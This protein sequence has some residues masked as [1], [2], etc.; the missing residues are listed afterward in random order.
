MKTSVAVLTLSLFYL[1]GAEVQR[2]DHRA[3]ESNSTA[4]PNIESS[5]ICSCDLT[6]S[7]K[8]CCQLVVILRELESKLKNTEKQVEDLRRE[9]QGKRVAFGATLGDSVTIGPFNVEFTL[10]Y[11][12]VFFNTGAYNP[13]TGIFT[14]PVKG[15][16]YFSFS[17]CNHSSRPLELALM[18]NGERMVVAFN[19][20]GDGQ[21]YETA[22]NGMTLQL[23]VGEQVYISLWRNTWIYG[24]MYNT[25][26]GHLLFPL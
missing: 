16:Y 1:S 6:G 19:H 17:G 22:T 9:V 20:A 11:K 24:N 13:A 25:F 14:A 10:T 18:K 21:R 2:L 3:G 8:N 12:S 23:E 26:I 15:V 4:S 5:G 7:Q